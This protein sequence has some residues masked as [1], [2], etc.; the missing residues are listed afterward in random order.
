MGSLFERAG[1]APEEVVLGLGLMDDGRW[2]QDYCIEPRCYL[3]SVPQL[4]GILL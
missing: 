2:S 4:M 3:A 1:L